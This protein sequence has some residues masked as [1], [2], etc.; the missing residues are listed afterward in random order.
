MVIIMMMIMIRK[1]KIKIAKVIIGNVNSVLECNDSQNNTVK[2]WQYFK[3]IRGRWKKIL[4]M[5]K[6]RTS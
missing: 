4:L 5:K 2:T 6:I 3:M 1:M